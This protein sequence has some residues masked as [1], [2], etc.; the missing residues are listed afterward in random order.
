[1]VPTCLSRSPRL[2]SLRTAA[3]VLST[4]LATTL[5]GCAA[6]PA[7]QYAGAPRTRGPIDPRTPVLDIADANQANLR[8]N[9][10]RQIGL[11]DRRGEQVDKFWRV[12]DAIL[13]L[14]SEGVL[15][16]VSADAGLIRWNTQLGTG[17]VNLFQPTTVNEGKAI[18]AL[19]PTTAWV[20]DAQTGEILKKEML[21]FSASTPPVAVNNLFFAG[22]GAEYFRASYIDWL[23]RL[24][25]QLHS[26][27]DTFASRPVVVFGKNISVASR[28]GYVWTVNADDGS[29]LWF[30]RAGGA[31][32]VAPLSSDERV[33]YVPALNNKLY[34]F[35][36]LS[37][38]HLWDAR[39]EGR[40]DQAAMPAGPYV[41]Q[42]GSGNGLYAVTVD[43]GEIKWFTPG[44]QQL[45][46]S[47]G[48][49][50][51]AADTA[52]RLLV[53]NRETGK[54]E[55]TVTIRDVEAYAENY[56][57]PTVYVI[58]RDGR[59]ASISPR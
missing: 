52:G 23:G 1:M 53:L 19:T 21:A 13:V 49:H 9:W 14:T 16:N 59:I 27:R 35:D 6:N 3:L 55:Q 15:H 7:G 34:A 56:A 30:K 37:G 51:F 25:W 18:L 12:G 47:S 8:V 50:V 48:R 29:T 11:A 43:R 40:L 28:N 44:V 4:L 31:Q 2:A 10:Q 39:L 17:P 22:T 45:V 46:S 38:N 24:K 5:A 57:N 42:I 41:L 58:T 32:V 26:P 33:V 36:A 20:I 54:A